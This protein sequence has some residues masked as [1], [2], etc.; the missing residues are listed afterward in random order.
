MNHR[1]HLLLPA[2]LLCL[3][4]TGSAAC[5]AGDAAS[6]GSDAGY[7]L[8]KKAA[9]AW[10][11]RE[12][13]VSVSLS[14]CLGNISTQITMPTFPNLSDILG[15]IEEEVCRAA[16]SEIDDY[17]PDTIDPWGDIDIDVPD[18]DI[19]RASRSRRTVIPQTPR[20]PPV[21]PGAAPVSAPATQTTP[22]PA[23]ATGDD[24]PAI[25]SLN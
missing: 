10:S 17:V 8:A 15:Q 4:L 6:A 18:I 11:Q 20:T 14:E 1:T 21:P 25:F 13:R 5:R 22:P 2:L 12:D 24:A 19:S 9:D 7:A 23:P 3:P 16:Q